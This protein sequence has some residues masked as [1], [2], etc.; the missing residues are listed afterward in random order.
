MTK[1]TDFFNKVQ[2]EI[3][4]KYFPNIVY[5]RDDPN[6]T[7]AHYQTELFNN[8]CLSYDKYI[9]RLTKLCK[10]DKSEIEQIVNQYLN[11]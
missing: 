11:F 5:Y 8:G 9:S 1:V 7:K 10:A 3:D 6:C 4:A 2:S